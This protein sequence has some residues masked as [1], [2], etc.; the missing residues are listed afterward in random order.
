MPGATWWVEGPAG[1]LSRGAV[2]SAVLEPQA[3]PVAESTPF[4]LAS[5]TKP[6]CTAVLLLLCR[7]DGLLDLDEPVG[8][9]LD[10]LRGSRYGG[11]SLRL[12]AHHAAGF[13]AW[14]PLYLSASS[15]EQY[16]ER[17]AATP[18]AVP[19]G[20][21]LYSDLG[22]IALGAVLQEVAGRPLERLFAERIAAPLG[23]KRTGFPAPPSRFAD[24]AA[25]ERGNEFERA[26]AGEEGRDHGWPSQILRGMPHDGNAR[27]LGGAAGHA[28]LFGPV[29][30]VAAIA[31]E[32]LRPGALPLTAESRRQLLEAAPGGAGRTVGLVAAAQARAA[33]GV[34][35]DGAPGHTGFT[36]TSLWLDPSR[37]AFHVLLANRVHPTVPE[38][39]FDFVR[40]GF[41]R[42]A[43]ALA[44]ES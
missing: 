2:G 3:E 21:T 41:H 6:L 20:R 40:R 26:L 18:P 12:L 27:A 14:R 8:S 31:R 4:D 42:L 19:P 29:A 37:G 24:A 10:A 9:Y 35:P 7:Q 30:E 28:G 32:L 39:G 23:L 25:T 15:L 34:L 43:A 38:R 11:A 33:R 36:G 44:R 17:I 13:P 5:L 16:L 1:P 22:Y